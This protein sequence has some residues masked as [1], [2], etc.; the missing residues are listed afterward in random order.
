MSSECGEIHR[1]IHKISQLGNK[2][3]IDPVIIKLIERTFKIQPMKENA[4]CREEPTIKW[5][6]Y[7][8]L[9]NQQDKIGWKKIARGFF[10]AEWDEIQWRYE[11]NIKAHDDHNTLWMRPIIKLIF[12]HHK[13]RWRY[14]N[15]REHDEAKHQEIQNLMQRMKWLYS[16][17]EKLSANDRHP[18]TQRIDEWEKKSPRQIKEWLNRISVFIRKMLKQ[19]EEREKKSLQDMRNFITVKTSR[20]KR[21]TRDNE[22]NIDE[23][24]TI[25]KHRQRIMQVTIHTFFTDKKNIK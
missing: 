9:L 22:T 3:K 17:K 19:Q 18:F 16:Q 5:D 8:L 1:L 24:Q 2:N 25:S 11:R 21:K 14:R 4:L 23:Q 15:D 20:K 10:A 6:K 13:K 7:R 12:E